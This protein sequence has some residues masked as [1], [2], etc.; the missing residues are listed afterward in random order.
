MFILRNLFTQIISH[1]TTERGWEKSGYGQTR[2]T[3]IWWISIS[4]FFWGG[5]GVV[6]LLKFCLYSSFHFTESYSVH[7]NNS[8]QHQ[9]LG[10]NLDLNSTALNCTLNKIL[11]LWLVPLWVVRSI[12]HRSSCLFWWRPPWVDSPRSGCTWRWICRTCGTY[13]C[14]ENKRA[15]LTA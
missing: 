1:S 5:G 9:N 11:Y 14:P 13:S 7:V 2:N 12:F 8:E 3:F 10:R 15:T 4:R 6:T